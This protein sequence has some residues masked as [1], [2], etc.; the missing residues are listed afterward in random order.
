[1]KIKPLSPIPGAPRQESRRSACRAA[2]SKICAV[3]INSSAPVRRMKASSPARTVSGEPTTAQDSAW[4][5]IALACG[6]SSLVIAFDRRRQLAGPPGAQI[7]EGLLQRGEQ[8]PR[9]GVGVGGEDVEAEHHI[10]LSSCSDGWKRE[11]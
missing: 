8:Q 11:R 4:S 9:L 1:M 10:G 6:S 3:T 7:D 5:S 2:W